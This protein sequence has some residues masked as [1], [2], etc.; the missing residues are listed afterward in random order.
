MPLLIINT[1]RI[2]LIAAAWCGA[3]FATAQQ[4]TPGK[5]KIT[6]SLPAEY[7]WKSKKI[8][9]DTKAIRGTAYTASGKDAAEAAIQSVT[10][11]TIDRRYFPMKADGSPQEK[12]E[13]ERADCPDARLEIIDRQTLDNRTAILYAVRDVRWADGPCGGATLLSYIAE[14]PTAFHTVE[15]TIPTERL[16]PELFAQWCAA[17]LQSRIE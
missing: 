7:R 13:Y 1:L 11:T 3:H 12:W 4:P 10:V 5:E 15:L 9:K 2:T 16:T 17:L 6:L 8:P 14:G